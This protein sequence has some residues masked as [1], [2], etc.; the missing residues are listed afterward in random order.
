MKP[1]YE[2]RTYSNKL[3]INS[4]ISRSFSFL[5]HWHTEIEIIMVLEGSFHV[6]INGEEKVLAKGELGVC[7]SGQ[8][9]F[10]KDICK[11]SKI[12]ITIFHPKLIGFPDGWPTGQMLSSPFSLCEERNSSCMDALQKVLLSLNDEANHKDEWAQYMISARLYEIAGL[13]TKHASFVPIDKDSVRN[14][15]SSMAHQILRFIDE[16]YMTNLTLEK[17]ADEFNVSTSH[18]SKLVKKT[19]GMSFLQYLSNKRMLRAEYLLKNSDKNITEIAF[20]CGFDS[21]RTFNRIFRNVNN[22]SPSEYRKN[23]R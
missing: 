4:N 23:I 9:H 13:I 17:V 19:S 8:I 11:D 20:D 3:P 6:G 18:L 22:L 14:L 1:Y 21:I 10:F 12:I 15:D 7:T 5:A 16:R 2:Y